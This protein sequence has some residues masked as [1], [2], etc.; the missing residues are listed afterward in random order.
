MSTHDTRATPPPENLDTDPLLSTLM[1]HRL[2]TIVPD[3]TLGVAWK[4]M[5]RSAVRHLPVLDGTRCLGLV[6]ETD[7]VR[8]VAERAVLGDHRTIAI[9][10]LCRAT[11]TLR[12][13]D[14]RSAAA[15]EMQAAS[16]DAVLVAEGGALLGIVT[17][18]DLIRSLAPP[19]AEA[20]S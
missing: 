14:R 18:V 6:S 9:G 8:N 19:I 13:S 5:D 20:S 12:P 11:P 7:L 16:I 10:E 2:V 17:A 15:R 1:T 4:L 3:A